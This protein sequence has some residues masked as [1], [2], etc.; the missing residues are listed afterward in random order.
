M[1]IQI[2][3]DVG[4]YEPKVIGPF[5]IRQAVCL[6][7]GSPI[8]IAIYKYGS[9]FL[10]ADA[11]SFFLLVP[12]AATW[13][14]GWLKPYGMPMERFLKSI[15]INMILAPGNRT[16]KTEHKEHAMSFA[17]E[18]GLCERKASAQKAQRKKKYKRSPD[19]VE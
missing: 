14:F 16:Y 18:E 11:V 17:E 4:S 6:L 12:A 15:F 1:E 5:T 7:I 10:P 19:G 13:L 2:N 9:M 8:C 3:K